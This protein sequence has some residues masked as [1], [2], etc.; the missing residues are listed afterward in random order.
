MNDAVVEVDKVPGDGAQLAG[1]QAEVMARTKRASS[2]MFWFSSPSR[3]SCD[4]HERQLV[5]A[6]RSLLTSLRAAFLRGFVP[7]AS[8]PVSLAA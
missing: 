4:R 6:D 7:H 2:R 3:P 1:A 5:A 8:S